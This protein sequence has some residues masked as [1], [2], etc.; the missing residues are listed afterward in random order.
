V[1]TWNLHIVGE[2]VIEELDAIG[3]AIVKALEDAG[4]NLLS[5]VLTTDSGST[6]ITPAPEPPADTTPAV[7]TD[8]PPEQPVA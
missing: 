1:A 2:K 5:A 8:T 7:A 3:A 6:D 4:H